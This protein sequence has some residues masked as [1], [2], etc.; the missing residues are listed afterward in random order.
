MSESVSEAGTVSA[1]EPAYDPAAPAPLN[2]P[3][4]PTGNAEVD[5]QL[6]RLADADHLATDGHVEV[7]EDVHGGLRDALT[8]LDARPG[9][10]APAPSYHQSRS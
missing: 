9:P 4:T 10:P 3:R 6:Q 7:Y 1:A 2:V 5:A 8:A